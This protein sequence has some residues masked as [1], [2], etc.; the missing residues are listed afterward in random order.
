MPKTLSLDD[1]IGQKLNIR[2]R[3]PHDTIACANGKPTAISDR[4][5]IAR[6]AELDETKENVHFMIKRLV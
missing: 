4:I 6:Q 2:I 5:S 3:T 1:Q